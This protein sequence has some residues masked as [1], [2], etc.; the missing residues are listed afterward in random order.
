MSNEI[1]SYVDRAVLLKLEKQRLHKPAVTGV[2]GLCLALWLFAGVGE[3]SGLWIYGAEAFLVLA[4]CVWLRHT[5]LE[6]LARECHRLREQLD[7]LKGSKGT[8]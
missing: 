2:V 1:K 4:Y 8:A 6:P 5:A 7:E 3:L